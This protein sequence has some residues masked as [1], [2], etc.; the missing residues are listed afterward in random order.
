[1]T[2]IGRAKSFVLEAVITSHQLRFV[3]PTTTELPSEIES[4]RVVAHYHLPHEIECETKGPASVSDV[5]EL[6][7]GI[8]AILTAIG[9]LIAAC[10]FNVPIERITVSIKEVSDGSLKEAVLARLPV[11]SV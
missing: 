7:R 6:L 4:V 10:T 9:P 5:I 8:Q 1:L 3:A 2:K 11:F